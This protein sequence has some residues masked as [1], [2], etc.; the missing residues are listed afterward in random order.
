MP[1][2]SRPFAFWK[3]R[4]AVSEPAIQMPKRLSVGKPAS[5]NFDCTSRVRRGLA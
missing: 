5:V 1:L 2:M 3:L 4:A